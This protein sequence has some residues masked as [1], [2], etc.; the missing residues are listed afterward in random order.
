[1]KRKAVKKKNKYGIYFIKFGI[2]IIIYILK[3]N[4]IKYN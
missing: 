4:I 2:T 1:M 3:L